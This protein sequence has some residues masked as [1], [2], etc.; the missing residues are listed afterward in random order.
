MLHS[1]AADSP[2]H[3]YSCGRHSDLPGSPSSDVLSL[4]S[5]TRTRFSS[6]CDGRNE[7]S[8]GTA[9][10]SLNPPGAGRTQ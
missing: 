3:G 5:A 9:N 10:V 7:G 2:D 8:S 6:R 4:G 1:G